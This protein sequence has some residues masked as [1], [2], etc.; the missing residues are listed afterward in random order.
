MMCRE[1]CNNL[2]ITLI[3]TVRQKKTF[4]VIIISVISV[5]QHGVLAS[6]G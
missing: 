5:F 3:M 1:I 6:E 4:I 2:L